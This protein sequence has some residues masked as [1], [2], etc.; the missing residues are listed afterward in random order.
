MSLRLLM[1]VVPGLVGLVALALAAP[2]HATFPGANGKIVFDGIYTMN[3]DGTGVTQVPNTVGGENPVW[4]PDGTRIA[5]DRSDGSDFELFVIN[6][7]GSG[8]T[9]LTNNTVDDHQ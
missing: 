7:D 3:P 5:F 1:R 9:H 2:A 4:S 6:A 8:L